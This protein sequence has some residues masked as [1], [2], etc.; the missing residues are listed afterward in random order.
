MPRI[1]MGFSDPPRKTDKKLVSKLAQELRSNNQSGQPF[2]YEQIFDTGKVRILVIWDDWKEIPLEQRIR[3]IL[4]AVEQS[5]GKD[6]RLKVALASGLTM[7]EAVAAG[8]LPYQII[9]AHR[10][11]DPVTLEQ[12]SRAMLLEGASKLLDP[13]TIQLWFPTQEAAEACRKRLVQGL[14]GSDEIW[15][16]SRR[17]V[18]AGDLGSAGDWFPG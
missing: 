2:I 18:L 10:K 4:S 9:A 12:C 11:G 14:P 8:M 13:G 16:I 6:Y 17:E 1:R 15:L 3:V 5:D 7:P